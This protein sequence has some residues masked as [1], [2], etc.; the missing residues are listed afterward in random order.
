LPDVTT[1]LVDALLGVVGDPARVSTGDSERDLHAE[2]LTYH[3]PHRPDVVVY[4]LGT[5]EVAGI[6]RVA[7]ELGVPV[8]PLGAGTSLEGHVI[9]VRGGI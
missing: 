3:P 9:P 6:L 7:A 4:A 5:P 1:A 8:T 2:D